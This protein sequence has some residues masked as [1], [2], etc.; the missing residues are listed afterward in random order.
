MKWK[1]LARHNDWVSGASIT[2]SVGSN[3][4]TDKNG[5]SLRR[6]TATITGWK[7]WKIYQGPAGDKVSLYVQGR[8][9]EI[10][11]KIEIGDES[12]FSEANNKGDLTTW[13]KIQK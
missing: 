6:F 12:V 2:E 3:D 8:V 11:D 5:I 9:R 4:E 13:R 10:R 1:I 7:N